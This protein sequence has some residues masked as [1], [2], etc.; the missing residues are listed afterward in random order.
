MHALSF[1]E[2]ERERVNFQ[3]NSNEPAT[4]INPYADQRKGAATRLTGRLLMGL[5]R[6]AGFRVALLTSQGVIMK[7]NVGRSIYDVVPLVCGRLLKRFAVARFKCL[8]NKNRT[9]RTSVIMG[10]ENDFIY[11][12]ADEEKSNQ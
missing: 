7:F 2:E 1:S 5:C 9:E 12:A 11:G 10:E 3:P 8:D 6:E 4:Y